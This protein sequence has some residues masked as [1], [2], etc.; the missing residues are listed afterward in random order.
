M[1]KHQLYKTFTK[2]LFF[3]Y[4]CL[5]I[6]TQNMKKILLSI[7]VSLCILS[8]IEAKAKIV[9][10]TANNPYWIEMMQDPNANFYDVQ[11]AFNTYWAGKT[12]S[13]SSGW[14]QFKRWEYLMQF[15]ID[16][17]GNRLSADHIYKSVKQFEV[18]KGVESTANWTNIGP[19]DLPA[20]IGTGQPNGMG[21]I[22]CIGFHP[23]NEN[24]IYIGAPQ[25]GLWKSTDGGQTW[26]VLTDEQPTLGVSSIVISHGNA[27]TILI[28]S[29]DRDAGDSDGMGVF[30]ST[31][32][33]ASW[34]QSNNG[35]GN[36]T[37]GRMIQDPNDEN[38]I[39]AATNGGIYKSTD[40]GDNWSLSQSGNFKD[41]LFKA[42]NSDV[43]FAMSGGTFYKSTDNGDSFNDN[44]TGLPD[45]SRGAIAT[46]IDN[47]EIIYVLLSNSS[48]FGSLNRS[49]DAG[50]NWATMS[51]SP[52]IFDYSCDGSGNN[53]QGWYDMDVAVDP[54]NANFVFVGGVNTWVSADG[55]ENWTIKSHWYGGCGVD[56][57]HADMH[58]YEINPLNNRLYNGNDGGIYFT[59]NNGDDWTQISS[60]IAISQIYKMGSSASV[61]EL[62]INGY[63][64]NGTATYTPDGWKTVMGGDGMDCAVDWDDAS[65]SYGEY[66]Y[67][68]IDRI[69]NNSQNQGRITNG[70]SEE[71]A[72]VTP[73]LI[74]NSDANTM[75]VGMKGVWRTNNVKASSTSQ[76]QWL[77]IS[78]FSG[79]NCDMLVQSS[80][81][82]DYLWLGKSSTLRFCNNAN[83]DSP[84]WA[85]ITELPGSGDVR[86]LTTDPSNE[87]KIY[88]AQGNGIYFSDD[89]GETWSDITANLPDIA[90]RSVVFYKNSM[91]GLYVGAQS[92]IYYK[93]ANMDEWVLYTDGFPLSSQVTELEIFY[94]P[95]S[96]SG[97][98][99]RAST[100]GRG[101]WETPM[102][103]GNV[104]PEF[105]ADQ[106]TVPSGCP[107][108]FT[109]LTTGVPTSW[110]WTFEGGTPATSTQQNPTVVYEN[111]GVFNV[112]LEVSNDN[113]SQSLTKE[114]Y[115]NVEAG[116]NPEVHFSADRQYFCSGEEMIVHFQ[117]E[118]L[119]CPNNWLWSFSP[120]TLNFLEGTNANSQNP[121]VEFTQEGS[122][123]IS[124]EVT[125]SNGSST[126]TQEN[127]IS[128][129]GSPLPFLEGF[130]SG[131]A[132]AS[133]WTIENDDSD[134]TWERYSVNGNDSEN[135]MGMNFHDY[136]NFG[137]RDRLIS[138]IINLETDYPTN[139]S[140]QHA[141]SQYYNAYTDSLIVLISTDCGISWTRI[142]A[143]GEDGNGSLATHE[144]M[145]DPF[146]PATAEDWCGLGW[147]SS[148]YSIDISEFTGSNS[149]KIAF[150]AY[151]MRGNFMYIDN[152]YIDYATAIIPTTQSLNKLF[153]VFPNPNNGK[154][155]LSNFD[156]M[157]N[158]KIEII[159][160]LGQVI[161]S[162]T[163]LNLNSDNNFEIDLGNNI[164]NGV[165]Y[166]KISNSET[167]IQSK[168]VVEK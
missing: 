95:I 35:M 4:I 110:N 163:D 97:D 83:S 40:L 98:M 101:L 49:T 74:S 165:Y 44:S 32:G 28:G 65:Y 2:V 124:L 80:A 148:C 16:Q 133:G 26:E 36:R 19:I 46:S 79:S 6:K 94:D 149:V 126:L 55:G 127:F 23:S 5:I 3:L 167:S 34:T 146:I 21:R 13:K 85:Q 114:D 168:F 107:V 164:A 39:I 106:T 89:L 86:S 154:F 155:I 151:N 150:E 76:V 118:S 128:T 142:M 31:D 25:G 82:P 99:L 53:G 57:V 139:L 75:F 105:T 8:Q 17:N 122:Y 137:A 68:A 156:K 120:N 103:Q 143:K 42:D 162:E 18:Q 15:K 63:Q 140:F 117:D 69:R 141:Y 134:I 48:V 11:K 116:L 59:D 130:E 1:F 66:Y 73:Y 27:N 22:N 72:W 160:P 61:R 78:N 37:V 119:Y 131:D 50:D 30:K 159:G 115:V 38:I 47:P 113:G 93:E 91:D 111:N 70:I 51:T 109:D 7:V 108:S 104:I 132:E 54:T 88:M 29:G 81:N 71:G 125:N 33:G 41:I 136:T 129:G 138:P 90:M 121:I 24:I 92:G 45:G 158:T 60:G 52:N 14:K 152:V 102:F 67:G 147:G 20:N 145:T 77:K 96:P 161:Y 12:P 43:V 84:T 135:A 56:A 58:V 62:V 153:D 87:N 9:N 100:F 157:K 166:I 10:D 64:D 144:L 112:T 123:N